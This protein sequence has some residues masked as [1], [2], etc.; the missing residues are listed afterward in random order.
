[1]TLDFKAVVHALGVALLSTVPT[2]LIFGFLTWSHND[3]FYF[4]V[5]LHCLVFIGA[6]VLF[7][8]PEEK[9]WKF[10]RGFSEFSVAANKNPKPEDYEEIRG[11]IDKLERKSK[12]EGGRMKDEESTRRDVNA[13]PGDW[14]ARRRGKDGHGEDGHGDGETRRRGDD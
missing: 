13:G 2:G 5:I 8:L 14:G 4:M 11:E 1:M 6:L 7:L 12:D 3:L 10:I 9:Q